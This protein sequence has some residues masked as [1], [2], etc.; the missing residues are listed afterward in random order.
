MI[1][2]KVPLESLVSI[3]SGCA[4]RV[5]SFVR[6]KAQTHY[7]KDNPMKVPAVQRPD[8]HFLIRVRS[9]W[10]EVIPTVVKG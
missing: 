4:S 3:P 9:R 6:M 10:I 5:K 1:G 2:E 7:T 8:G